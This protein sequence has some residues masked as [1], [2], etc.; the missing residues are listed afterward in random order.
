VAGRLTRE[1]GWLALEDAVRRMTSVAA[2]R[3]G[4]SDRGVLRPG[5]AADLV[6]FDATIE[7][8]ATYDEPTRLPA[9]IS[10]VWVAGQPIMAGGR[11]S[12]L[13]PGRALGA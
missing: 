1:F 3:F 13:R 10:D 4:L 9:G 8:R 7:D 6:L 12:G 5:M 2:Q 11:P